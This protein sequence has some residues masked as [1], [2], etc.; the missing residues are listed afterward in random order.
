MRRIWLDRKPHIKS[1]YKARKLY[2]EIITAMEDYHKNGR[3]E[4]K[5]DNEYPLPAPASGNGISAENRFE[6]DSLDD[7]MAF[8]E[9]I[10]FK[11]APNMNCITE[12][13]IEK[14]RYKKPEK[15]ELL[16]SMLDS[17]M[18][19]FEITGTDMKE[20]YAYLKEVFTGKEYKITDIGL[21]G[22][23]KHDDIYI[24]TR[25]ISFQGICFGSGMSL[26]FYKN[27][28]FIEDHIQRHK[29]EYKS[30]EEYLRFVQLYKYYCSNPNRIKSVNLLGK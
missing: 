17:R 30:E 9:F 6:L 29:T 19:L 18:G 16:Q 25:I 20:G 26:F 22:T 5:I 24:Y 27:E 21:S 1:Y 11:S 4:I 13:F 3:F 2:E 7:P 12:D 23:E 15:I 28:K 8:Y 10:V 14:S